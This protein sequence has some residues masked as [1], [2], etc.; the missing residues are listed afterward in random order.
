MRKRG[1]G[2][3]CLVWEKEVFS[4]AAPQTCQLR[5]RGGGRNIQF[6]KRRVVSE[7]VAVDTVQR[8]TDPAFDFAVVRKVQISQRV[9][10]NKANCLPS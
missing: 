6:P 9:L 4:V 10:M 8:P 5:T 7:H 2:T 1:G 3:L